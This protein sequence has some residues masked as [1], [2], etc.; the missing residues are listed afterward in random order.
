LECL[1]SFFNFKPRIAISYGNLL[2]FSYA[3]G[4]LDSLP[5]SRRVLTGDCNGY[6]RMAYSACLEKQHWTTLARNELV[7]KVDFIRLC[8]PYTEWSFSNCSCSSAVSFAKACWIS[9]S[10]KLRLG[11]EMR[12]CS[13]RIRGPRGRFLVAKITSPFPG[14]NL[15]AT[16]WLESITILQCDQ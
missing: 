3:S 9:S 14:D 6:A 10:V 7:R 13:S 8:K 16:G 1:P 11:K 15:V 4:Q 12:G 5:L 2:P